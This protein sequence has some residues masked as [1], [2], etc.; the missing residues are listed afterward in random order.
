MN[1]LNISYSHWNIGSIYLH[2]HI[3]ALFVF[4]CVKVGYIDIYI[5]NFIPG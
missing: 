2:I 1:Q 4:V 3:S 5:Y